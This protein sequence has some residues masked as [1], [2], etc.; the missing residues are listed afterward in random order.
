VADGMDLA[1]VCYE[2]EKHRLQY[3]GA[4]NSL[5]LVRN[6][7]NTEYPADRFSIGK[8]TGPD[9]KFTNN[10]VDILPGDMI[11]VSSD[12]YAD[13]FGG[14]DSKKFKRKAMIDLF[15]RIAPVSVEEQR[16]ILDKSF[17][18]WRKDIEQVDDV[19]VIGRRF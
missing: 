4:F 9:K 3:A 10:E 2:P 5:Y 18:D 12:G 6:G 17:E 16:N 1:L 11:F 19:L 14:T 8:N 13:Q 15:V 7:E